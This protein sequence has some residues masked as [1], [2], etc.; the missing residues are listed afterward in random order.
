MKAKFFTLT[1]SI[2][3]AFLFSSQTSNTKIDRFISVKLVSTI[4]ISNKGIG[5]DW[6]NFLA[7]NKR[8]I[9]KDKKVTFKLE[10]R[11]PLTVEAFAIEKDKKHDDVG[12]AEM[13]FTYSDL[14]AVEN[15]Q[16]KIRIKV[17][18]NSGKSSG[19]MAEWEYKFELARETEL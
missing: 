3:S 19:N 13:T 11:A 2:L 7:I 9:L 1:I 14:I 17:M 6:E 16:F 5:H 8:V 12:K 18:E 10:N 15:S 4:Q